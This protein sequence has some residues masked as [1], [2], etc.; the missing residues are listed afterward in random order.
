MFRWH[1]AGTSPSLFPFGVL[2]PTGEK[3]VISIVFHRIFHF[4]SV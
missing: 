2:T 1:D 4:L 3:I